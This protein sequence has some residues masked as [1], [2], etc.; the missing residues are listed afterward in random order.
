[1]RENQREELNN[2]RWNI[3]QTG[4]PKKSLGSSRMGY[5]LVDEKKR[6]EWNK[7]V[8]KMTMTMLFS[9]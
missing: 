7:Y 8:L 5:I 9:G 2:V 4:K 6:G 1:M 3:S